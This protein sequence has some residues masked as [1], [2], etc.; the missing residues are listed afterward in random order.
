MV[1]IN[2]CYKK[3]SS[4]L[5][6]RKVSI[7]LGK[8]K[9]N[10]IRMLDRQYGFET[11]E[12]C[13][14]N[15]S[16]ALI[17]KKAAG[18]SKLTT[19]QA[20]KAMQKATGDGIFVRFPGD[21]DLFFKYYTEFSAL[22]SEDC[23]GYVSELCDRSAKA[24]CCVPDTLTEEFFTHVGEN[25]HTVMVTECDGYGVSLFK[26]ISEHP[27]VKFTLTCQDERRQRLFSTIYSECANVNVIQ[28]NIYSYD[29]IA[30]KFDLIISVPAFGGRT[31][32]DS[33]DFIS[34]ETDLVAVQNLLYHIKPDG[35]LLIVVPA[36][37]TFA[38]GA[39][40]DLRKYIEGNYKIKG[41]IAL[42]SGLFAPYT[43]IR[44]YLFNFA[45]GATDDIQVKRYE[46]STPTKN[47]DVKLICKD[48]MLLF[49]DEFEN[50]SGWNID[51]AFADE[52]EDI[53]RFRDSLVKKERLEDVA[54]VFRGRA[55]NSKEPS[56]AIGVVNI[57][58]LGE[59][60]IDYASLDTIHEDERKVARYVLEDGD[61]LVAARGT[62]IKVAVFEKQ[63]RVCIPSVNLNVIRTKEC[64]RGFY[65]K[66]FL[67]SPVGKKLL[68]SLQRGTVVMNLNYKDLNTLE[69]PILPL[70]EQDAL[71]SEY[72]S[73]QEL[74]QQTVVAATEAWNNIQSEIKNKLF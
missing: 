12:A 71:I 4:I 61:V 54:T 46:L 27:E 67:E 43:A 10:N 39:T 73:G 36:K 18:N 59:Q 6:S 51:L 40:E 30:E 29:F 9:I 68:A 47:S 37:I 7:M 57:S 32:A 66:L 63:G 1:Y 26:A 41:I 48:D 58:N 60:G 23:L 62:V 35:E 34:R 19:T 2:D 25:V 74:Y 8:T 50:L 3:L 42:P 15:L 14:E 64:L 13:L 72:K 65:L 20:Y 24:L 70:A 16:R 17:T 38:G 52:D 21:E 45:N 5:L 44:T 11:V 28:A 53:Q 69:I 31:L 22:S 33:N 49:F 56:G 55:V